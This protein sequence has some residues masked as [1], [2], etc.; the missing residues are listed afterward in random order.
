MHLL[1]NFSF[2]WSF[3]LVDDSELQLKHFFSWL[4]W[5]DCSCLA[6][7]VIA[8][9]QGVIYIG[10]GETLLQFRLFSFSSYGY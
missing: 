10:T 2:V 3:E 6:V 7:T 4:G 1:I 5:S 8:V 9:G